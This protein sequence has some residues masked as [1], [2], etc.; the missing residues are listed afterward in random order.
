M[1]KTSRY[2]QILSCC[3]QP[4]TEINTADHCLCGSPT[5]ALRLLY[6]LREVSTSDGGRTNV[7]SNGS[8]A[9]RAI[10]V[11]LF[12]ACMSLPSVCILSISLEQIDWAWLETG[13]CTEKSTWSFLWDVW[14]ISFSQSWENPA[15]LFDRVVQS[16]IMEERREKIQCKV[17]VV[18]VGPKGHT[19]TT[20]SMKPNHHE[21]ECLH[22]SRTLPLK[23]EPPVANRNSYLNPVVLN[24]FGGTEPHWFHMRIHRTLL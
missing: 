18:V 12:F 14:R 6:F 9:D 10:I 20:F 5:A 15:G 7:V 19:S 11:V 24:L 13:H 3:S 17:T 21:T 23:P 1:F 22:C 16:R 4:C 2:T 8:L